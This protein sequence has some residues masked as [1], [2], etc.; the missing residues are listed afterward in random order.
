MPH[1]HRPLTNCIPCRAAHSLSTDCLLKR[2]KGAVS[3]QDEALW[4]CLTEQST[5]VV[6]STRRMIREQEHW[7]PEQSLTFT[8]HR[9][10]RGGKDRSRLAARLSHAAGTAQQV[11]LHCQPRHA[12]CPQPPSRGAGQAARARVRPPALVLVTEQ[13]P[14]TGKCPSTEEQTDSRGRTLQEMKPVHHT[15]LLA[16]DVS[17]SE[18]VTGVRGRSLMLLLA[19]QQHV[20]RAR[21]EKH[22]STHTPQPRHAHTTAPAPPSQLMESPPSLQGNRRSA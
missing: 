13:A 16:K 6:P 15:L 2:A 12:V 7:V 18:Q 4:C 8:N 5:R 11:P 9:V 21:R 3:R 19:C 10:W 22:M 20:S 17:S 14:R 1:H